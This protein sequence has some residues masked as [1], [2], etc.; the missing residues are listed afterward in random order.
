MF[1]KCKSPR[2][3]FT[4]AATMRSVLS[5]VGLFV[6]HFASGEEG[7]KS[8]YLR[9]QKAVPRS[10]CRSLSCRSDTALTIL[11]RSKPASHGA[12]ALWVPFGAG[13]HSHNFVH[14]DARQRVMGAAAG[15]GTAPGLPPQP[16]AAVSPATVGP[17]TWR[18]PGP[19]PLPTG[20]SFRPRR[21]AFS[22][23]CFPTRGVW[24]AA[25]RAGPAPPNALGADPH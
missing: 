15:A 13:V 23:P 3:S 10:T 1:N 7:L 16:T 5:F 17:L 20:G 25:V 19:P 9:A 14:T 11:R 18:P 8:L 4:T 24:W 21:T 6:D 2:C 12:N 22:P